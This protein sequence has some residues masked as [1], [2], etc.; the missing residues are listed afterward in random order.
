MISLLEPVWWET[1]LLTLHTWM[2]SSQVLVV[3]ITVLADVFVFL[4]PLFLIA[5]YVYGMIK[6]KLAH[7]TLCIWIFFA[8]LFTILVNIFVQFFVDKQRPNIVLW[9][10]ED[11]SETFL[12]KFLPASS[13]P[14]DHS[15]LSMW[16]A[17][18]CL[19]FGLRYK[20]SLFIVAGIF[21]IVCSVIMWFARITVAVHW[22][23]DVFAWFALW[24]FVPFVLFQK[25]LYKLIERYIVAP[26]LRLEHI[27]FRTKH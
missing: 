25:L 12:H 27:I 20:K 11:T 24:L 6:R 13:F 23:T 1:L 19:L 4:Y 9:L 5:V 26:L 15:A 22:P 2:Q 7:K 8:S 3:V 17:V 16:F 10:V 18:A 21:F 14:S